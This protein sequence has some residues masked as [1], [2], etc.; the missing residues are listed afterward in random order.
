VDDWDALGVAGRVALW[1]W[2]SAK[3]VKKEDDD[4]DI[5]VTPA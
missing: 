5:G 2:P 4:D 3:V 1:L